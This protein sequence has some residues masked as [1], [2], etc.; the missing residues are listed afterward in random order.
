MHLV[1]QLY[2]DVKADLTFQNQKT[3]IEKVLSLFYNPCIVKSPVIQVRYEIVSCQ[4]L[5][6]LL[7]VTNENIISE[8][9]YKFCS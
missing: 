8:T 6:V 5:L 1:P 4:I 2:I 7:S 3:Q 9:W